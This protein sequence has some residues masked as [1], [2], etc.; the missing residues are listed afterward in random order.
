MTPAEVA[1]GYVEAFATGDADAV[2]SKV[3]EAFVNE[4][5]SALG[6]GV[7]GRDAYRERLPGF[8]G[9]FDG[10]RY[11]I[12]RILTDNNTVTVPYRML[13]MHDG[14][15]VDL[16]GVMVIDVEG[17]LV[18]RRCD[19]WDSLTFLRQTGQA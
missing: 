8:L 9:A 10:L 4:H 3:T 7:L 16:R 2:A 12:E 19:Y 11:E 1:R 17:D 5:T 13:A 14:Q 18:A 15:Q 6:S